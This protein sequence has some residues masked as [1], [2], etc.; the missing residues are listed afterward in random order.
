MTEEKTRSYLEDKARQLRQNVVEMIGVGKAGHLGGSCSMA[1]VVA[2]L[3][4]HVMHHDPRQPKMPDRDRFLLSKGHAALIQY[5]ALAECGY[6]DREWFG[7]LKKLGSRLQGHPDMRK[8]PGIEANT[9]SLGQGVSLAA[10]LAAGLRL[11]HKK[12]RVYVIVG[13]GELAEGQIW[14]AFMA[15][16]NYGLDNLCIII[17]KNGLQATGRTADRFCTEPLKEKL[18]AFGLEQIEIDGHDMAQILEAFEIAEKTKGRPTVILANT[19]KGKGVSF[20]ENVTGFH[21]GTM[22]KE[23]YDCAMAELEKAGGMA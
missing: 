6:F 18:M 17:D 22:T 5:A 1:D 14:E 20:A 2:A 21:N 11:D 23:Q 15:A 13:D 4:F 9:G 16:V 10:G 8:T 12:A 3:Y 7:T 19:V